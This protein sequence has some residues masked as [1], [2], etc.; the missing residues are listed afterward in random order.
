VRRRSYLERNR[1][2]TRHP[3]RLVASSKDFRVTPELL[4]DAEIG[5]LFFPSMLKMTAP[6]ES[7]PNRKKHR[8]TF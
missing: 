7:F 4:D 5:D 6:A 8:F 3:G 2:P 1:V